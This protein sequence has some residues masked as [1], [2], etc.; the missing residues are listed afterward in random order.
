MQPE[1]ST[2]YTLGVVLQPTKFLTFTF[3]YYHIKINNL[4]ITADCS[5]AVANY[6]AGVTT[7]GCAT[8]AGVPDPNFPNA[9]P[10]L[11]TV[12]SSY[13]NAN[14]EISKGLDFTGT[15]RIPLGNGIRWTSSVNAFVPDVP[16]RGSGRRQCAAL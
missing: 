8:T 11:G 16:R 5:A 6:Y 3:D 2:Q 15:A 1:K 9:Q 14:S 4:I 10:L 12:T 13:I 7:P